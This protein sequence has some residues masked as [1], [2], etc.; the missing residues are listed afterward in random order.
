MMPSRDHGVLASSWWSTVPPTG[1]NGTAATWVGLQFHVS[2][3][4]RLAGFRVFVDSTED[5]NYRVF[6]W[7][8]DSFEVLRSTNFRIR[9]S[10]G[11]AWHQTWFRPWLTLQTGHTYRFCVM[12]SHG[13][14]YRTNSILTSAIDH[15]GIAMENGFQTTSLDPVGAS[16]TLNTNANGIDLLV[17]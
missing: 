2:K 9:L 4:L 7:D 17:Y 11:N 13:H 16:L 3:S 5:G 10:S 12:F 6:L 15:G 8:K 14:F 1:P